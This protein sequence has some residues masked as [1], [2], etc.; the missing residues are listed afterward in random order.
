MSIY[1]S[2]SSGQLND[3]NNE[4][5]CSKSTISS[6]LKLHKIA[7]KSLDNPVNSI[8]TANVSM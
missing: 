2:L 8:K 5:K 4:F 7:P 6:N 3:K 1:P